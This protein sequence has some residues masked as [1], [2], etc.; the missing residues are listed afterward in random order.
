MDRHTESFSFLLDAHSGKIV[1]MAPNYDNNIALISRGYPNDVSREHDGMIRLFRD[2][3]Q[4]NPTAKEMYLQIELPEIT[5]EIIDGC[6]AEIPFEV[7]KEFV[8]SFIMNGQAIVRRIVLSEN[9]DED[10][11]EAFHLTM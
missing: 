6:L 2:F 5:E 11:S 7:D 8:K 3:L 4:E 10:E 1:S 9:L